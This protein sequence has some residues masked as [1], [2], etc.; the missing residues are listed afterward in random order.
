MLVRFAVICDQC[1]ERG[2]EYG[3]TY[4]CVE[5]QDD[6]CLK[7]CPDMDPETASGT[8]LKCKPSPRIYG[9][10]IWCQK[11]ED[12]REVARLIDDEACYVCRLVL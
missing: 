11:C 8:C 9:S 4:H 10:V 6:V 12:Y 3:A 2:E 1:G 7:C 5:C